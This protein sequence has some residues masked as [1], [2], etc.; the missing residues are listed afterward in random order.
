MILDD[1]QT[2]RYTVR[3]GYYLLD[4]R[5][6]VPLFHTIPT[7][8]L[9]TETPEALALQ[10]CAGLTGSISRNP[11]NPA[12][13]SREANLF[14]RLIDGNEALTFLDIS[15]T[16]AYLA[17]IRDEYAQGIATFRDRIANS[18][19]PIDIQSGTHVVEMFT[20]YVTDLDAAIDIIAD[21]L[22]ATILDTVNA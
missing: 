12:K 3:N 9:N 15:D 8:R 2:L 21:F 20:N 17:A 4:E 19:D 10:R 7:Y 18:T 16:R 22:T 14:Q 1:S 13:R 5:L 6:T 11:D